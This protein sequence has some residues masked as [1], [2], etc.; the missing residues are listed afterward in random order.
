[1]SPIVKIVLVFFAVIFS[2]KL[3][4]PLGLSLFAGS[5]ALGLWLGMPLGALGR[6]TWA[7][8]FDL[9][10]LMLLLIV[11]LIVLFSAVLQETKQ[12]SK[13]VAAVREV[14]HN[15]RLAIPM[16]TAIIGLLPMPGGARFSAPLVDEAAQ[17]LRISKLESATINFWFRHIW[18]YWWPFYPSVIL[19]SAI[20]G[21]SIAKIFVIFLP[22]S[23]VM[24]LAGYLC[25]LRRIPRR[26]RVDENPRSHGSVLRL[27]SISRAILAVIIINFALV[28]LR[29]AFESA[30]IHLDKLPAR[31]PLVI[32][33]LVGITIALRGSGLKAQTIAK[34]VLNRR[35][36]MTLLT[37]ASILIFSQ[38]LKDAGAIA[39]ITE[40]LRGQQVPV[41]LLAF[42][43]PF[44]VS[45][46]TGLVVAYVGIGLPI[47]Y[48]VFVSSLP[49]SELVAYVFIFSIAG[50]VA[51]MLTPV[52]LCLILSNE[53][54]NVAYLQVARRL[55]LPCILSMTAYF[56]IFLLYR[57]L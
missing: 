51:V 18:E 33:L 43:V 37:V 29:A 28:G 48:P 15:P 9:P 16:M 17:G 8:V 13:L 54:F 20:T 38:V 34:M 41:L 21:F 12:L 24:V 25:Y 56:G 11:L 30:G 40:S 4:S 39:Q 44:L 50:Y 2:L 35:V 55:I 47:L 57:M 45:F 52:H 49:Q 53:Y 23:A 6:S 5:L 14:V 19:M 46:V 26:A 32:A 22:A 31:L 27:L 42:A 3:K 36:L 10:N 7:G 1:M